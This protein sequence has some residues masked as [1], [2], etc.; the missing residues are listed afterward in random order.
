MIGISDTNQARVELT[1]DYIKTCDFVW[2]VA[3]ISRVVDDGTVYQLLSRYGKAFKGMISVIC[4]HSDE[5]IVGSEL[6]L[7]NHFKQEDQDTTPFTVLND[8]IKKKKFEISQL[9]TKINAIRK[10]KKALK[11]EIQ[12]AN[13]D[14]DKVKQMRQDCSRWEAERFEFLVSTRNALV[15][16]Q[17]QDSM[18]SHLPRGQRLEVHCISSYH[19][20]ALKG[21]SISGPR[22]TADSTGIPKLRS[23]TIALMAPRLLATLAHYIQFSTQVMLRDLQ[24]WVNS[25]CIDRRPELLAMARKPQVNFRIAMTGR[26]NASKS[27]VKELVD[28]FL[29]KTIPSAS[30]AALQQLQNKRKKHWTTIHAFLRKNGNHATR[31]CPKES[32]NENFSKF[33]A[34]AVGTSQAALAQAQAGHTTELELSIVDDLNKLKQ[35]IQGD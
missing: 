30:E 33:F 10:R 16:E 13:V 19:Y 11:A 27:D 34:E 8:K 28:D 26:R 32:W 21:A 23:N 4:T 9:N 3:P 17:L 24:L 2:V 15:V 29:A 5:G 22:L 25:T 20:A 35:E 14:D 7:V 1:H 18:Q 12:G 6:K 31:M